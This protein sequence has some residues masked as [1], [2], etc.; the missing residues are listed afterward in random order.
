MLAAAAAANAGRVERLFNELGLF[1]VWAA[2]ARRAASPDN[3]HVSVGM[4]QPGA[5]LEQHDFGAG[6]EPNRYAIA[7]RARLVGPSP[8]ARC[9]VSSR[10]GAEPQRQLIVMT[11]EAGRRRTMFTGTGDEPPRVKDGIATANGAPTP[12]LKKCD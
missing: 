7:R 9:A 6:Y 10:A 4:P 12:T 11:V 2:I 5:V 1:G 3:P 8:R